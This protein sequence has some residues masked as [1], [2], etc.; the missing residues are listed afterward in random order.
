M[1]LPPSRSA[2]A[3]ISQSRAL[4]GDRFRCW[5][6]RSDR[7]RQL[8]IATARNIRLNKCGQYETGWVCGEQLL[9]HAQ[10][11]SHISMEDFAIAMVDEVEQH[12]HSRQRFTV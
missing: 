4:M 10:G 11:K 6:C 1:F 3:S 12:A 5:R 8:R 7:L 9:R 2:K